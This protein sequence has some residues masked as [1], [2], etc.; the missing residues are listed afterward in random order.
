MEEVI[1]N[2]LSVIIPIKINNDNKFIF[3]RIKHILNYFEFSEVVEVIIIDSTFELDDSEL[4]KNIIN[5]YKNTKYIYEVIE[6]PYSA[7]IARNM[8]AKLSSGEYVVF[9]DVDLICNSDFFKRIL[10]DIQSL[11]HLSHFAFNVY[12]CLYLSREY[13]REIEELIS[14]ETYNGKLVMHE[15]LNSALEGCKNKVLYPAINTSTILVNKSHFLQVGGY[16]EDFSGHGY[17]DFYLLHVLSSYYPL[18]KKEKDYKLDYKTD[19]PGLYLGFRRHFAFY[20]FEN[21]FRGMYTLHLYHSRDRNK[22]YYGMRELN[23]QLFQEKLGKHSG[24]I[25]EDSNYKY[26]SYRNFINDTLSK[27]NYDKKQTKGLYRSKNDTGFKNRCY[28]I[29]R[30]SRKLVLTP[31][32]FFSDIRLRKYWR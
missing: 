28:V 7:A 2:I 16:D 12:P 8:G 29:Y 32:N 6:D 21:L 4:L 17:E 11:R 23:S 27:Y 15:A 19:Y 14:N 13:S 18:A 31:K 30:K 9:F 25:K 26:N 3:S 22:K 1:K 24:N 5:E 20:S 10:D